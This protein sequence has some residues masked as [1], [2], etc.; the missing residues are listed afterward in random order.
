MD[1]NNRSITLL[2]YILVF[3][4]RK[5]KEILINEQMK[6]IIQAGIYDFFYEKN[7]KK[8]NV[9]LISVYVHNDH[10]EINFQALP[11]FNLKQF[12]K[13]LYNHSAEYI[14]EEAKKD[15]PKLKEILLLLGDSLWNEN[16]FLS[17]RRQI[18]KQQLEAYLNLQ[19]TISTIEKF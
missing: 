9:K 5:F 13:D 12:I 3:T 8:K 17:S 1:R 10:V 6:E 16:I 2:R 18:V 14:L 7:E 15:V 11:V 4:I 19:K